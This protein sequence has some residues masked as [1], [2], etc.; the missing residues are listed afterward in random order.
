MHFSLMLEVN[1]LKRG[2]TKGHARFWVQMQSPKTAK[3]GTASNVPQNQSN[4][5]VVTVAAGAANA[6]ETINGMVTWL[7]QP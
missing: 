4:Q 1:L 7:L 3:N 2:L 6:W 5:V